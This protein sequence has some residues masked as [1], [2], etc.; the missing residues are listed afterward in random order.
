MRKMSLKKAAAAGLLAACLCASAA[1]DPSKTVNAFYYDGSDPFIYSFSQDFINEVRARGFMVVDHDAQLDFT[2]Q[3]NE[4]MDAAKGKS[5]LLVNLLDPNF[6]SD[7]IQVVR[8]YGGRVVFFNRIPDQGTV[9]SYKSSW[10]VGG[11]PVMAGAEQAEVIADYLKA[12][13]EAD[14]NHDGQLG[15]MVLKGDPGHDDTTWRTS[16]VLLGLRKAG[17]KVKVVESD[18]CMWSDMKAAQAVGDLRSKNGS[19]SEVEAIISNNDSMALGAIQELQHQGYNHGYND[20]SYIPVFG[21]DGIPKALKAAQ[22]GS[23]AGT[24]RQDYAT[25]AAISAMLLTRAPEDLKGVSELTHAK[26]SGNN[27]LVPYKGIRAAFWQDFDSK[28]GKSK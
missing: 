25:M 1:Q 28:K 23:L 3:Y 20:D 19:L 5:Q 11:E 2:R 22:D 4:I 27:I 15:V 9:A 17:V 10:Y 14:R 7:I 12:H 24:V 16:N 8:S 6:A 21:I 26:V 18:Y 13:P